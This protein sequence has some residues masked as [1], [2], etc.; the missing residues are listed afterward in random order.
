VNRTLALVLCLIVLVAGWVAYSGFAAP[1]ASTNTPGSLAPKVAGSKVYFVP[2]GNVPVDDLAPLAHYYHDKMKLDVTVLP[3]IPVDP[4]TR[5]DGREQLMAEKLVESVRAGLPDYANDPTAILIGFTSEDIYPT[6]QNWKFAFG[7]RLGGAHAAVVSTRR[8]SLH[9]IG[10][11][12]DL[13][14]SGT[15]LRKM[16]TKDIGILY[17]G[18]PQSQ[19]PSSVLYNGIMGI[20]E[21]D[22]VGE[23]F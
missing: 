1:H 9:Y 10:E 22:S 23:D 7:W 8:M 2:L 21:L 13:N 17:Y 20:E 6:S 19:N 4:A 5:D 18:L 12:S 14:L 11:P 15:R 16:V 3:G